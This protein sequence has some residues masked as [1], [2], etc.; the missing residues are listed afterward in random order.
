MVVITLASSPFNVVAITVVRY[1]SIRWPL[2]HKHLL[3]TT[4]VQRGIALVWVLAFAYGLLFYARP[5]PAGYCGVCRS[6]LHW[7]FHQ[8]RMMAS[9]S[10]VLQ[11]NVNQNFNAKSRQNEKTLSRVS[12]FLVTY[13]FFS[14]IPFILYTLVHK[15]CD[16][17][18]NGYLRSSVRILLFSNTTVNFFAYIFTH[19]AF[20]FAIVKLF[21]RDAYLEAKRSS[22]SRAV[23]RHSDVDGVVLAKCAARPTSDSA[24]SVSTLSN[25]ERNTLV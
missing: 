14:Y 19:P 2:R 13:F 23:S 10:P 18:I 21:C 3:T 4:R 8:V 6:E 22:V 25:N 5:R 9:A 12:T 16:C 20:R 1:M 7:Q 24:L 15:L 17:T 11:G